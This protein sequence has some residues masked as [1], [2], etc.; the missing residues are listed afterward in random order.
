MTRRLQRRVFLSVERRA[1]RLASTPL[2]VGMLPRQPDTSIT[3]LSE[4]HIFAELE[5]FGYDH[6]LVNYTVPE[7]TSFSSAAPI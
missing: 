2:E 6:L 3:G 4:S 1:L 7:H 5:K